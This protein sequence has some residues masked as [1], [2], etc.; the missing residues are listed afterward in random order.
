M[1]TSDFSSFWVPFGDFYGVPNKEVN[2]VDQLDEKLFGALWNGLQKK[3]GGVLKSSGNF[4]SNK[5]KN[6][7][8]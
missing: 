1:S 7:I 5:Y 4:L 8:I 3:V 2:Y 6:I